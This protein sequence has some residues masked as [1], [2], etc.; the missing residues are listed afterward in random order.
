MRATTYIGYMSLGA[1]LFAT[2]PN[3]VRSQTAST[4]PPTST[5]AAS[6][7]E[8]ADSFAWDNQRAQ[9]Q[10]E[11]Q[12]L[13]QEMQ[14]EAQQLRGQLQKA[15]NSEWAQEAKA[16]AE[17]GRQKAQDLRAEVAREMATN[18]LANR[19][20]M[21]E[22][23]AQLSANA[24]ELAKQ[25]QDEAQQATQLFAQSPNVLEL[26]DD[27]GW[28]GVEIGEVTADEAKDMKLPE[29]RGVLV[30]DVVAE[31]PAAKAGLKAKDVVLEYDGTPVEGTVQFR[32]LVRE[33]PPGRTVNL[34]VMRD[35]H[36]T[37]VSVQM[38]DSA[39]NI[40]S[41][42]RMVMP[43]RPFNFKFTMPE[44]MLGRTPTLGIEAEDLSG[45]LGEFFHVPGGEGVLVREVNADT[46]A[47]KAGLKA[48]DVITKVDSNAVKSLGELRDQLRGKRDQKS[49]TLTIIREGAEKSISVGI[50]PPP[51]P[52]RAVMRSSAL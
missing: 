23:R 47:A 37:K 9:W 51:A 5:A 17:A 12:K 28:L 48:G 27:T 33:T 25:A 31:S 42:L 8:S 44:L 20:E 50:E 29:T 39:R 10:E 24:R 19:A 52:H 26:G 11:M 36:E 1:L 13:R 49:V 6:T 32:R 38:G 40:E 16:M 46:P 3:S 14:A 21:E 22:M 2:V 15:R 7:Q 45:Q 18:G 34:T 35:G 43:S 4:T 30:S 41:R